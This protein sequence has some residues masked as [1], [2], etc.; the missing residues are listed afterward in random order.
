MAAGA[1][2]LKWFTASRMRYL[3]GKTTPSA[4]ITALKKSSSTKKLS[5]R[6]QERN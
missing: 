1:K 3:K 6:K 4:A 2:S 5:E